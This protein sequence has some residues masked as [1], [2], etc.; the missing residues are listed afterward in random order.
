MRTFTQPFSAVPFMLREGRMKFSLSAGRYHSGQSQTPS[1]TFL[2]GTLFYG[3]PA[4]FTLYGGS[5][6]AQDYQSGRSASD[7][8]L[9]SWARL[10]AMRHGRTPQRRR[11]SARRATRCACS[12]RRILPEPAPHLASPAIATPLAVIT[13]L[14]RLTRLKAAMAWWTT[15]AA[16]RKS[17]Y[18][19]RL[20][21]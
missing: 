5:Q 16:G 17:P 11:E 8:V 13:T 2:Q 21:V 1:P 12:T 15:S 3:L 10:G 6:L 20:A 4:E 7:A 9:A 18:R 19:R 14:V